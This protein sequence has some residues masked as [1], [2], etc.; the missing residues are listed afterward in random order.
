VLSRFPGGV[1]HVPRDPR[2]PSRAY[3]K[4]LEAESH[5]GRRIQVGETCVDLGASPGGWSFVAAERGAHV[6]AI[7]RAPLREDLMRKITFF[8][9]DAFR[10]TPVKQVDWLLCDLIAFPEKSLQ[11]LRRWLSEK[12]CRAYCVTLK[13]RGSEDYPL[14]EEAKTILHAY[15]REYFMRHLENNKNEVTV[16][17]SL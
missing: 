17:G 1:V 14:L 8:Q 7:D 10:Y 5:F 12:L 13:F 15:S 11:L 16:F 2:P 4:L 6:I 9:Q 3:L